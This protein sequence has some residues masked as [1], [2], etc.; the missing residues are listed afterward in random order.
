MFR[1]ESSLPCGIALV[2][3][4]GRLHPPFPG[5]A[6]GEEKFSTTTDTIIPDKPQMHFSQFASFHYGSI[7]C[8]LYDC[9]FNEYI[10]CTTCFLCEMYL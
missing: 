8:I 6:H 5:R 2:K 4:C 10:D 9:L 7:Q 3:P 1:K